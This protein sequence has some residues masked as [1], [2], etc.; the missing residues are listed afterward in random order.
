MDATAL[1]HHLRRELDA[2]RACLDGDLS[3]PVAHCAPWT[4][5]ELAAHLAHGNLRAASAVTERRGDVPSPAAPDDP[6]GL[7]RWFDKASATLWAAL[8]TDPTTTAWT[9][10]PPHT[11]G[12][13]Q[14]RRCLEA[15]VHRWDA[16]HARGTAGPL[17]PELA[18]EGVAEVCDT[19]APRQTAR[20]RAAP[21]SYALRLEATDTGASWTYGPG[22][23]VATLAGTAPDLLL[24]LW[25]RIPAGAPAFA[26]EG[27]QRAGRRI[28]DGPL[29]P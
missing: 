22:A 8:N 12:F 15:L 16:Q 14:R 23:P 1:L 29:V 5:G 2:F 6:A 28:L 3:A 25:G 7:L 24:L 9:F 26:W 20:G 21:P 10:H 27:D 4:L 19:L 18:G 13:W 17:D 11:V